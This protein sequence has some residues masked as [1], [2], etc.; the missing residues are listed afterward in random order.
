MTPA[1]SALPATDAPDNNSKKKKGEPSLSRK[2]K[3]TKKGHI[4]STSTKKKGQVT[5]QSTK[6]KIPVHE[7]PQAS[8]PPQPSGVALI[9]EALQEIGDDPLFLAE[10]FHRIVIAYYVGTDCG[11]PK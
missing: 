8:F 4:T 3:A 1:E 6:K 2:R 7:D 11:C 5:P 10:K 9:E